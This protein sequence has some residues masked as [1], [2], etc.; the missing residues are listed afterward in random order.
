[1]VTCR[2]ISD[3]SQ[4]SVVDEEAKAK[5]EKSTAASAGFTLF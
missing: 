5:L 4:D 1:M 2:N 3:K